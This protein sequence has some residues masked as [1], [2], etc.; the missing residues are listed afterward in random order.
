MSGISESDVERLRQAWGSVAAWMENNAPSSAGALNPPAGDEDISRLR[1]ALGGDIPDVLEVWLR[2]NNGSTAKDRR[3]P[4]SGGFRVVRHPDSAVFPLG[5][6]FLSSR[7]MIAH[8]ADYLHI[9]AEIGD[10][11]YWQ[12]SW[13]PVIEALDAPYGFLLDM[14]GEGN[15]F[16]VLS[17]SEGS[18]PRPY[19]PSLAHALTAVANAINHGTGSDFSLSGTAA[20]AVDG[21]IT[22][23]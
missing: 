5:K 17:F 14:K 3:E 6:A 7:E 9:A 18:Y 11:D 13:I 4:I 10:E 22:W 2:M 23:L 1:S 16:P 8:R 21:R 15:S 19:A 12:P 20:T